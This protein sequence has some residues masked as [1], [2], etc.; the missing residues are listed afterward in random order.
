MSAVGALWKQ[1]ISDRAGLE[2]SSTTPTASL[3]PSV[4]LA[5]R[6]VCVPNVRVISDDG[7]I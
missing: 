6:T 1:I 7:R 3:S 5:G 4:L 2:I